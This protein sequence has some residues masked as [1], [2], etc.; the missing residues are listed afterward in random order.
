M[1]SNS[2]HPDA[3]RKSEKCEDQGRRRSSLSILDP[4]NSKQSKSD[5]PMTMRPTTAQVSD[6][7]DGDGPVTATTIS[8]PYYEK[9][10]PYDSNFQIHTQLGRYLHEFSSTFSL[11]IHYAFPPFIFADW[12]YLFSAIHSVS[13]LRCTILS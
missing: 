4:W 13:M 2:S 3:G 8:V 10:N 6:V 5:F 11:I 1:G 12:H 7:V 9:V